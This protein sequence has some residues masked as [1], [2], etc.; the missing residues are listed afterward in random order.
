MS[1]MK[2]AFD[3]ADSG[4]CRSVEAICGRLL[5]EGLSTETVRRAWAS[6]YLH[7]ALRSAREL[8]DRRAA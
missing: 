5:A 3:L 1:D 2:R 7:D 8:R 6:A 4:E